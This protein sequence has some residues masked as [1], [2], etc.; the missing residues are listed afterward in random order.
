MCSLSFVTKLHFVHRKR[1][2]LE[3]RK[4]S[5]KSPS[6]LHITLDL[7]VRIWKPPPPPPPLPLRKLKTMILNLLLAAVLINLAAAA[8][9]SPNVVYTNHTVGDA[10]GWFFNSTNN[11]TS[12]D[13]SA[14]AAKQTFNLGDYL[15]KQNSLILL[16]NWFA[17]I[18]CIS[19]FRLLEKLFEFKWFEE[20]IK[21][22]T[23]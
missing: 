9:T 11:K 10:A 7:E 8:T 1:K 19:F 23:L 4:N 18:I 3:P 12:T 6:F 5:K 15:S 22:N 16:I 14:W 20:E 2:R 13:Y 17:L 21:R